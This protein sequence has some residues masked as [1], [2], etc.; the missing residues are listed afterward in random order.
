MYPRAPAAGEAPR[1]QGPCIP[2][3]N[4]PLGVNRLPGVQ[5]PFSAPL[6]EQK[7]EGG[8]HTQGFPAPGPESLVHELLSTQ[9][10]PRQ[11]F[12]KQGLGTQCMKRH[13]LQGHKA[14]QHLKGSQHLKD[15]HLQGELVVLHA[16]QPLG[17]ARTV[18]PR[19]GSGDP[20]PGTLA[21][22]R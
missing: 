18:V 5:T 14:S 2:S 17:W 10:L 3:Q 8:E 1:R 7:L 13:I 22:M 9:V 12:R 16:C 19:R 21:G 20:S 15:S 6:T 4:Q 11:Q